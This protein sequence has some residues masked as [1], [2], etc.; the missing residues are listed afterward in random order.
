MININAVQSRRLAT[1]NSPQ[2]P[3]PPEAPGPPKDSSLL[4]KTVGVLAAT[5]SG[6]LGLVYGSAKGLVRGVAHLPESARLGAHYGTRVAEPLTRTLGAAV[7]VSLT[8]LIGAVFVVGAAVAPVAGFLQGVVEGAAEQGPLVQKLVKQSGDLGATG[9][10][11]V[12]GAVGGA[13]GA[14]AGLCTLPTILY[15]PLGRKLIPEAVRTGARVG[16]DVGR[17]AG[18]TLGQGL[19]LGVGAVAGGVAAGVVSTPQGLSESKEAIGQV[20]KGAARLPEGAVHIWQDLQ[21]GAE[22]AAK[23]SGGALGGLAGAVLGPATTV[24]S[25]GASAAAQWAKWGYH[26][27][28][29]AANQA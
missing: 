7:A 21:S 15:P 8:G 12:L 19:G 4:G 9:G 22:V 24:V 2:P 6:A 11:A 5:G 20:V 25:E 1:L 28:L 13:L 26:S 10:S 14:V 18:S 17:K 16:S 29:P 27:V 23:Y 3:E